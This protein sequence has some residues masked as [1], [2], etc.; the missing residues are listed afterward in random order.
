MPNLET[1]FCGLHLKNPVIASS[2]TFGYG[3]EFEKIV[4]LNSLGGF[5]VKGLSRQPIEGNPPPR[6]VETASGMLNSIGLQNVGVRAFVAEKLP[7]LAKLDTAVFANIFGYQPEDY[8]EVIRILEDADGLAGYEL[9]VSCPN[10]KHGGME[11][12]SDPSLLSEVVGMAKEAAQRRPL[13]VKLSPNVTDI[14][15]MARSAEEAG[16]DAISLVNTFVGLAIDLRTRRPILGAR[17]GGLSGPAIKPIALRMVYQVSQ[18][19]KVPVIGMGGI[20]NGED[21]AEFL[22][23]G[24]VAAQVGTATFW[25]PRSPF[26]LIEEFRRFLEKEKIPSTAELVGTLRPEG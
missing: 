11:F 1:E 17:F 12:A 16:A 18:A 4:D 20:A 10:T 23:C 21:V 6:L 15:L 26:R 7:Q 22:I 13:I 5:V 14:A 3:L 25:D 8:V 24:A 9:N 19:V 2:G